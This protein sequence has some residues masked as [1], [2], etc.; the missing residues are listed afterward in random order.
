MMNE[1]PS[2]DVAEARPS[3]SGGSTNSPAAAV[4]VG[5]GP[6]VH[7][8]VNAPR[9]R[10]FFGA[11]GK[12][13]MRAISAAGTVG[14]LLFGYDQ[15]VLSGINT[16]KDFLDQFNDP[17]DSLLG[18][19]SA[20]Y[21]IGC[22]CGAVSVFIV[23]E[24]LG[25]RRCLYVGAALMAIGAILQATSFQVAQM[26]VGRIV[27][28]WGNGFNTA[29]TPLWVSELSPA[30]SRG[31]LVAAE[32][33]LI[34]FG[35]VIASYYNIGM[36][37]ASGPVVW[38]APIATQLVFII[39]QVGLTVFLPE[40]P[41][42]LTKHGRHQ[43]AVDIL[44]QLKGVD[45]PLDDADV[46]KTKNEIDN[47]LALE[48]DGGPWRITEMFQSGPLKIR[49]RYIL[50][51]S[52]QAMQQLSG[53]NLLVYFF[54]HILTTNLGMST[55][56]SLQLAAGLSLTYFV[57]S[58][59]PLFW[60]DRMSRRF[61]LILGAFVCSFC[62]LIAGALQ[63]HQTQTRVKA[64]LAFFF[65]YEALFGIGW[66][67]I[68]WLYPAEIMPLRHRTHSTA[69][70]TASDWIFNYMIVQLTPIMIHN[71]SWK[72]YMIFFVLNFVFGVVIWLFYPETT[73]KTLEELDSIFLG[74][75]D[76]IFVV[77]KAGRLLPAFQGKFN[78]GRDAEKNDST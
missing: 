68:P 58:L 7:V 43:D 25:R 19:I 39:A 63:A 52:L 20:I 12:S 51:I 15:G 78:R 37:Y 57:F 38:R 77:N 36:Y 64:S 6:L 42:W 3:S 10:Y 54:P 40:S 4:T 27:C 2:T 29:T 45:V 22:F 23:G 62:F 76:R 32:G 55:E 59:I 5:D 1:K 44:A 33:T 24:R 50:A 41:R 46:Q 60:L 9:Q 48:Q 67:A 26:I 14:F 21:E 75:G 30:K 31:R 17:S 11:Q 8:D 47:A 56:T 53:I 34:A 69:I 73:G 13:L 71:I 16:S 49:R 66:L 65:L 18:T 35:I 72:S 61:P 74:D 70:A 28:G